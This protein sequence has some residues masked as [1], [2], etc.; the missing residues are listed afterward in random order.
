MTTQ[1]LDPMEPH[2]P[3]TLQPNYKGTPTKDLRAHKLLILEKISNL[4]KS[5]P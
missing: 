5:A 2:V 1:E 4:A 3:Y